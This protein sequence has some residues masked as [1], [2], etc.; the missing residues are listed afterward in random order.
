MDPHDPYSMQPSLGRST[1]S[2]S[3]ITTP[4]KLDEGFSEDVSY[5]DEGG[6][7][8][9]AASRSGFEEWVMAQSEEDRAGTSIM[10]RKMT[11]LHFP[12]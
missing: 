11:L 9:S 1:Y 4:F 5:Q 2:P 8:G 10:S 12:G 6:Q 3:R 7:L